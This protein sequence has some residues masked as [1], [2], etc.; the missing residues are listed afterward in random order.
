MSRFGYDA[1]YQT[2]LDGLN[3][4]GSDD[5]THMLQLLQMKVVRDDLFWLRTTVANW[6]CKSGMANLVL[7]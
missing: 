1:K 2:S 4:V 7:R 6:F 5:K 3:V